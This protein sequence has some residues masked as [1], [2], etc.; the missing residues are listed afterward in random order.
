MTRIPSKFNFLLITAGAFI[1]GLAAGFFLAPHS[2]RNS[3]K[4][5]KNKQGHVSDWLNEKSTDTGKKMH[6][7]ATNLEQGVHDTLPDLFSAT[8]DLHLKDE[9][10]MN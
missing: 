4:W 3:L 5:L 9:D 2:G 6:L 7:F 1:G 8:E 10:L